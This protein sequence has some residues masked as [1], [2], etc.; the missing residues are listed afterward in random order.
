MK[1]KAYA[2]WNGSI[3]D[4]KGDMHVESGLCKGPY[5][6]AS[7][8]EDGKGTNPEELIG[9]AHAGCF[10]MALSL[11]LGEEG[12][13][14]EE[15]KTQAEVSIEKQ[16]EGFGI[17]G[18]VLTTHCKIPQID[19]QTFL[20]IAGNAKEGCPVSQALQA[21]PIELKASLI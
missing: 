21:V 8:F 15:I 14:P 4:G 17:T 5:S 13:T 11:M 1:R 20:N 12:F 2:Q 19:E 18:I 6:F 10:S 3:K 7:R 16:K 9:A